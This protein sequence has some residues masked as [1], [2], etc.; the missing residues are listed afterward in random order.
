MKIFEKAEWIYAGCEASADQY[1]EYRDT[2]CGTHRD[3]VIYLSA[4]TDYTLYINGCYVASNQY[5][6]YEH[7]KIYDRIPIGEYLS[8]GDNRID[9]TLYYC[10][11]N[12]QRYRLATAG[13]IYEVRDGERVLAYSGLH[14]ESRIS[15]V[16][17]SGLKKYVSP[18]LGFTFSYDAT[19][20]SD[21]GYA[22][23]V[24][25]YKDVRFFERPIKR[26]S[27]TERRPIKEITRSAR[28]AYL[29]DLGSETVG[30]AELEFFSPSE[31]TVRVAWGE[32]LTDGRVRDVIDNRSFYFEYRAREGYNKFTNYMLRIGCRYLEVFADEP[33]DIRYIGVRPQIYDVTERKYVAH[34][35]RD[36]T[37]Y[38][39]CLNTLRLCM[40]EH[41]VDTPWREQC[42]YAFDA[43]NQMLC[44]YIA[45]EG[46]NSEYA[47]AN[48]VLMSEDKRD[49]GLLSICYP[50]GTSLAIPSFSLYYI[51]A[52]KEY[53]EYTGDLT[54]AARYIPKIEGIL[55]EFLKS[56][57]DGLI[58]PICG[59]NMWNFYDWS[60]Y[61]DGTDKSRTAPD[62]VI[63]CLFVMALD[64]L[65]YL[66]ERA[67]YRFKYREMA[68]AMRARIRDEFITDYGIPT[69]RRG[70]AEYTSLGCALAV[71]CGAL[72]RDDAE[73]VCDGI[74]GGDSSP[75][76]LSMNI[77]KYEALMLTN[78]EK[79]KT[80][81]LGEIRDTYGRMIDNGSDTVWETAEGATAFENAG[82]LCHGWSA[83]PIYVLYKLGEIIYE[84]DPI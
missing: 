80:Y 60:R 40:M 3:S 2:L 76:S 84:E 4:D 62:L 65:E 73:R 42:L 30:C 36:R 75:S 52:M 19:R 57:E 50:C 46:G 43:R 27:L 72:S 61:L 82:S 77:W 32:S 29:I 69:L 38:E 67:D 59:E 49:D 79:Y 28:G 26:L 63:N 14:T 51:I 24:L 7:Y 45:L 54:L 31:Q 55:D 33:I 8:D 6:D 15:P 68:V 78:K 41:Y 16:Y 20:E 25:V 18:Q 70:Y 48:L 71:L 58:R 34:D 23:S 12:T 39:A 10:G 47:R 44:G 53:A 64:S 37:I 13:L 74:V 66:C 83:V 5:G 17:K 81:I 56:S 21:D 35:R 9:I 1:T 11:V 22:P